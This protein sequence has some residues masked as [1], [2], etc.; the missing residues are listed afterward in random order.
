M[1]L[2]W[3]SKF[4]CRICHQEDDYQKIYGQCKDGRR[5]VTYMQNESC[6]TID[7]K[8]TIVV[9]TEACTK[10]VHAICNFSRFFPK[11]ELNILS[12]AMD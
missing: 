1:N 7:D 10:K 11:S 5:Q 2:Q 9:K 8:P 6:R 3:R 4:A 12:A